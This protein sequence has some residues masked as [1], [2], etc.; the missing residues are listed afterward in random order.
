MFLKQWLQALIALFYPSFCVVCG[1][2][3]QQHSE[4]LCT[5]CN[6][7]LPRT[8]LQHIAG[9]QAEKLFWGKVHVERVVAFFYYRKG[10]DFSHIFNK[11]KYHGRYDIG[12][13]MGNM[14]AG[15]LINGDF[16]SGIDGIVPVPLH[17]R[18][19]R[20]RGYNQSEMIA[21][22]IAE[23]SGLPVLTAGLIR[24][25]HTDTQTRKSVFERWNNVEGVFMMEKTELFAGKH[26]L[27]IDDVLTTGATCAACASAILTA[28]DAKVSILALALADRR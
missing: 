5:G 26:I 3:L 21:R 13:T 15:E 18:K 4:C 9:N 17:T 11:L 28:K 20:M 6:M 24:K 14:M 8:G 7:N 23:V 19:H 16:F 10:S 22:G 25:K 1:K 27:L 2:P 12:I